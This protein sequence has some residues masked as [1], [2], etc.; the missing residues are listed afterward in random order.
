MGG[1]DPRRIR[2]IRELL[3]Q[4]LSISQ[5]AR[6]V[7]CARKTVR[8]VRDAKDLSPQ[9]IRAAAARAREAPTRAGKGNDRTTLAEFPAPASR[10]GLADQPGIRARLE[11]LEHWVQ[12][13]SGLLSPELTE[14]VGCP[15]CSAGRVGYFEE[16]PGRDGIIRGNGFA[17][18][19]SDWRVTF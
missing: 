13:L 6:Q 5:I 18:E 19:A 3:A 12:L 8:G 15:E 11:N 2:V 7:G 9:E 16:P 1:F 14:G 10:T 4:G 17:C